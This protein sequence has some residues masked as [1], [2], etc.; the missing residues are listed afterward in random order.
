[1]NYLKTKLTLEIQEEIGTNIE[2]GMTIKN[3]AL[4]AG[5]D[6]STFYK[7]M[8]RGENATSGQYFQFVKYIKE[9]KAKSEKK[10]VDNI[11][12]AANDG[13]WQA[14]AWILERRFPEDW[15]RIDRL[16]LSGHIKTEE[17]P[18]VLDDDIIEARNTY[19]KAVYNAR[20][21]EGS[22]TGKKGK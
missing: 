7:W 9:S 10:H 1:M 18:G 15:G 3:A 11:K 13:A 21:K 14:S 2:T 4:A 17:E 19:L 22:T 5:I 20:K 16:S 8:N 6:E 12:K